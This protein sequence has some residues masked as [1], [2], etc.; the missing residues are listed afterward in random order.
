MYTTLLLTVGVAGTF[1]HAWG[2]T[3]QDRGY[4]V[5]QYKVTDSRE[6]EDSKIFFLCSETVS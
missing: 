2:A 1:S 6:S 5:V 4:N 3:V